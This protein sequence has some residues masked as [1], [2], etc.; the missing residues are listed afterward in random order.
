[1]TTDVNDSRMFDS[2]ATT[3]LERLAGNAMHQEPEYNSGLNIHQRLAAIR[4]TVEYVQ[5]ERTPG[6]RAQTSI[7]HETVMDKVQSAMDRFGVTCIPVKTQVLDHQRIE[8]MT[9][10]GPIGT[11]WSLNHY[12]Y[13]WTNIDDPRD[14]LDVEIT[15]EC[16]DSQDWGQGK[17]STYSAKFAVLRSLNLRYGDDPDLTDWG[18][19]ARAKADPERHAKQTRIIELSKLLYGKR[20]EVKLQEVLQTYCKLKHRGDRSI[21]QLDSDEIL[22]EWGRRWDE[23]YRQRLRDSGTAGNPEPENGPATAEPKSEPQPEPQPEAELDAIQG[24]LQMIAK[25]SILQ[26]QPSVGSDV[27]RRAV[28]LWLQNSGVEIE[29][30]KFD[31]IFDRHFQ[32]ATG[33]PPSTWQGWVI[34]AANMP[35]DEDFNV[36]ETISDAAVDADPDP[37]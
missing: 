16:L 18:I 25:H 26:A 31:Q 37:M 24:A 34:A 20:A 27:A 32:R 29:S 14:H 21:W 1:M 2:L 13:R 11:F 22:D 35:P 3:T 9:R 30:L 19:E 4:R 6:S 23:M 33:M 17:G 36:V 15:A 28:R 8:L 5:K 7:T 12:T 10:N